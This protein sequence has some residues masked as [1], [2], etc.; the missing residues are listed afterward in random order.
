MP[1]CGG[2]GCG[3]GGT[4][5]AWKNRDVRIM[6]GGCG[7]WANGVSGHGVNRWVGLS[8]G[9]GH[10]DWK[11]LTAAGLDK[12]INYSRVTSMNSRLK[13]RWEVAGNLAIR[14]KLH[15]DTKIT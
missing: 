15:N 9:F 5:C 11:E 14:L 1:G 10:R 8:N 2:T 7:R 12:P 3:S 4:G 13:V 6:D